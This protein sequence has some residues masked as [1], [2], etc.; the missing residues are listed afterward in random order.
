MQVCNN[1]V[2]LME[3]QICFYYSSESYFKISYTKN[4]NLWYLLC[5]CA[6]NLWVDLLDWPVSL[7]YLSSEQSQ[8]RGRLTKSNWIA[9]GRWYR[10]FLMNRVLRLNSQ[11]NLRKL[12]FYFLLCFVCRAVFDESIDDIPSAGA[13]LDVFLCCDVCMRKDDKRRLAQ[14]Y[15]GICQ[16]KFC[17]HHM[18]VSSSRHKSL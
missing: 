11:V 13:P 17:K 8:T 5:C 2:Q 3:E 9:T 15:C 4:G 1:T 14:I 10:H 12:S 7:F 16:K 18:D 6:E